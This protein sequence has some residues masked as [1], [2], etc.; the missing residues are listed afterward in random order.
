MDAGFHDLSKITPATFQGKFAIKCKLFAT[1]SRKMPLTKRA[2]AKKLL[3]QQHLARAF[4]RASHAALI[5]GGQA[6]V[7]AGQDAALVGHELPE[8]VGVFEIQRVDGE[9]N[10]RFWTRC[11]V[12]RGAA[13]T[14]SVPFVGIGFAWHGYLISR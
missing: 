3:H 12:F 7:F 6:G 2:A 5:M 4:D 14:A 10:F 13:R 11:A 9:I 8:Q 1:N